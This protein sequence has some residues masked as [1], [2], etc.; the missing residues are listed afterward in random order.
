MRLVCNVK[1]AVPVAGIAN[2]RDTSSRTI[3]AATGESYN[4]LIGRRT[5]WH[6]WPHRFMGPDIRYKLLRGGTSRVRCPAPP[7]L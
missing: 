2:P 6:Q 3:Y 7:G 4:A 1:C 5:Q